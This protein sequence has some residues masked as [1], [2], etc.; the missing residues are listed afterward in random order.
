MRAAALLAAL[1]LTGCTDGGAFCDLARPVRLSAETIG[2]LS[3]IQA[4]EILTHNRTGAADC[5]WKP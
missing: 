3:E 5:G 2:T 4:R 1:A